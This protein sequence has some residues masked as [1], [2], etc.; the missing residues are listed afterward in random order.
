MENNGSCSQAIA[1]YPICLLSPPQYALH[2]ALQL[3]EG[4]TIERDRQES[5]LLERWIVGLHGRIPLLSKQ[6]F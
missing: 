1:A 3:F 6:R 4:V 2:N 5:V